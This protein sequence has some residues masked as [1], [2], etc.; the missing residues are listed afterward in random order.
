MLRHSCCRPNGRLVKLFFFSTLLDKSPLTSFYFATFEKKTEVR[1]PL[2]T[3]SKFL[4]FGKYHNCKFTKFDT[5]LN[6]QIPVEFRSKVFT[7]TGT[8]I[9]VDLWYIPRSF[10][11][12]LLWEPDEITTADSRATRSLGV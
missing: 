4:V 12:G 9:S 8:G 6:V 3:Q 11:S 5:K 2:P 7:V 10:E 1:S